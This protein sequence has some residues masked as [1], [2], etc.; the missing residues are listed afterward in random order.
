MNER[1]I[2]LLGVAPILVGL[3]H[4]IWPARWAMPVDDADRAHGP[5]G[6]ATPLPHWRVRLL[7]LAWIALGLLWAFLFLFGTPE[8][9]PG[10]I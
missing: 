5:S 4:L 1:A 3:H 9:K 6:R 10:D 2:S 8:D 7:G